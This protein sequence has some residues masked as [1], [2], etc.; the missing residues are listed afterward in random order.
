MRKLYFALFIIV[1]LTSV[2]T[3]ASETSACDPNFLLY[4]NKSPECIYTFV[5]IVEE[6]KLNGKS[7]YPIYVNN[8]VVIG[9]LAIIFNE[10]PQERQ[11]ILAEDK[12]NK[13]NSDNGYNFVKSI[14]I[15]ALYVANLTDEAKIYA[16]NNYPHN[17]RQPYA[18]PLDTIKVVQNPI[19][20]DVLIGAFLASGDTKIST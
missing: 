4:K 9:A 1:T 12:Y 16:D 20:N 11:K 6:V 3:F 2:S 7:K 15:Q 14:F 8:E 17:L 19:D 5:Q 10:M 13:Y 18:E